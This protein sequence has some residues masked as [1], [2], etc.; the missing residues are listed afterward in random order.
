MGVVRSVPGRKNHNGRWEK[1][2]RDALIRPR[3]GSGQ[4]AEVQRHAFEGEGSKAPARGAADVSRNVRRAI[5]AT[6]SAPIEARTGAPTDHDYERLL[7][8][9]CRVDARSHSPTVPAPR[10]RE[11]GVRLRLRTGARRSAHCAGHLGACA[12]RITH[13]SG[14]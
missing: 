12:G 9:E 14:E 6:P 5:G 10:I 7:G 2:P 4:Q 1:G 3:P 13:R 11:S 8:Q